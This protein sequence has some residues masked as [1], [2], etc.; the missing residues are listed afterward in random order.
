M[1]KHK[2]IY[3]EVQFDPSVEMSSDFRVFISYLLFRQRWKEN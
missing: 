1:D 3:S 2:K